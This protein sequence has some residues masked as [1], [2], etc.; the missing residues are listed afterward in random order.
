[1]IQ[2]VTMKMAPVA[3]T[4]HERPFFVSKDVL[5][6]VNS[7][8]WFFMDAFWMIDLTQLSVVLGV[9]TIASGVALC[10]VER[11]KSH[12]FINL[13]ILSWILMNAAW[14]LSDQLDSADY[15]LWARVFFALGAGNLLL[16]IAVSKDVADTFSHFRRFRLKKIVR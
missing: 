13:G 16:A 10:Y 8:C 11:R 14:M 9:L 12:F 15:R 7:V 5:D 6:T 2:C 4:D 1:M 3:H